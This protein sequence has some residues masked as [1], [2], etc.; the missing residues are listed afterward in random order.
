MILTSLSNNEKVIE[1]QTQ[2]DWIDIQIIEMK[3]N[4][5]NCIT[6]IMKKENTER[7]EL[8]NQQFIKIVE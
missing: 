2:N 7:K 1:T 8:P 3:F 5:K 4:T 6:L